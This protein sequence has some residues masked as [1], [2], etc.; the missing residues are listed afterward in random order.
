MRPECQ[1]QAAHDCLAAIVLGEVSCPGG[2][3]TR[4]AI[5]AAL[6]VLCWVLEHDHNPHFARNLGKIQ[7]ELFDLG[8]RL[9]RR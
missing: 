7:A 4:D 9:R 8:Y 3:D 1:I 5:H 6:D 2:E